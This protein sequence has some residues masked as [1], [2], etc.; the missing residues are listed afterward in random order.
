MLIAFNNDIEFRSRWYH[1]QTED[2]GIKDGHIT[3]TVFFS[4]QIL[5]SKSISYTDNIKDIAAVDDQNAIIKDLMVTQHRAFYQKLYEGSYEEQVNNIVNRTS[6]PSITQEARIASKQLPRL[7]PTPVPLK[8][9]KALHVGAKPEPPI[10]PPHLITT[11]STSG[12]PKVALSSLKN[13]A[14]QPPPPVSNAVKKYRT[15]NSR[16]SFAGF[17]WSDEDLALDVLTADFLE[18]N[19]SA[20]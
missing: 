11:S 7:T 12:T 19:S 10:I 3:T 20:A 5:E 6:R 1:I 13:V 15:Q 2:N 8:V 16:L 18:K 17:T 4:G 14:V 9:S